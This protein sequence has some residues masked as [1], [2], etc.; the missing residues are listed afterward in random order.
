MLHNNNSKVVKK[1]SRRSLSTN[2]MRNI[3]V[4]IAII[5]T[6]VLLTATFTVGIT[7]SN[8][9]KVYDII[10]ISGVN[11]DGYIDLNREQYDNLKKN[12]NIDKIGYIQNATLNPVKNK[13]ISK[14][15]IIIQGTDDKEVYDMMGINLKEG[16]FPKNFEEIIA[17]TWILDSLNLKY[18]IGEKINLEMDINGESRNIQFILS[19]YYE[20]IVPR[21]VSKSALF[22]SPKFIEEIIKPIDSNKTNGTALVTLKNLNEKSTLDEAKNKIKALA[23]DVGS[24]SYKEH[25]KFHKEND[26]IKQNKPVDLILIISIAVFLLLLSG[27]LVIYNIF[28]ISVV[29]DI[30]FYGLL[31]TIGTTNKQIKKIILRQGLILSIIGIPM[32]LVLGYLIGFKLTP[33]ILEMMAFGNLVK[34]HSN[35]F[36]FIFSAIFSLITVYI[37]CNKSVKIAKKISPVEALKYSTVSTIKS[38]KKIKKGYNGGK[39]HNMAWANIMKNKKKVGISILSISISAAIFIFAVNIFMGVDPKKHADHQMVWDFQI[40]NDISNL[41][42]G[43]YKPITKELYDK[44]SNLDFVDKTTIYYEG[45]TPNTEGEFYDFSSEILPEGKI[46]EEFKGYGDPTKRYCGFYYS[47]DGNIRTQISS[48]NEKELK[49]EISRVR[50]IDG[51]IKESEFISGNYIILYKNN[52][53]GVIKAGDNVP[54]SFVLRDN[55]GN[56]S[57]VKEEFTVMAVVGKLLKGSDN[58][59]MTNNLEVINIE[60]NKFKDVFK[61][62]ENSIKKIGIN[63]KKDTNLKEANDIISKVVASSGNR[64]LNINSKYFFIE[65]IS[66]FKQ[67][68]TIVGLIVSGVLAIIGMLNVIN[69]VLTGILSR[70]VEFSMLEAIGMTKKQIKKMIVFEGIYYALLSLILILPLGFGVSLLAPMVMPIYS[71]FNFN[72]YAISTI[73]SMAVNII[74]MMSVPLIGYKSISKNSIV[75]RLREIE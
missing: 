70:K 53:N 7:F 13:E 23:N 61:D 49:N 37:S 64:Q 14:E 74:L 21:G 15:N 26:F 33:M 8:T 41:D 2:K 5:L 38:K 44:L 20:S 66:R 40:E 1:I 3:F 25:P 45:I 31:K 48:L 67:I 12:S 72:I 42:N 59:E 52:D 6:T 4:I 27:Y 17:P 46:G 57:I 34:V 32:G 30:R 47:E 51:E 35:P 18:N 71:S 65:G 63:V 73:I 29:R 54:I 62:Y 9:K 50:I 24:N 36:I 68:V 55:K 22:V 69:T 56:E 58:F 28:Y 19:G 60:E 75:E 11:S 10:S 39:L 16:N 43:E